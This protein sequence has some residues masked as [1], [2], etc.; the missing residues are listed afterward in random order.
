MIQKLIILG[1]L[2]NNPSS[3]YDIKKF[4][5]KELGVFSG[6]EMHSIYYPLKQ[7]EKEGVITKKELNRKKH[8][9]KSIYYITPKGEKE[10]INLCNQALLS[11]KRPFIDIDIPLY[12]CLI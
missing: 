1:F 8:L 2:K 7:M 5:E 12:F 3:G 4:I 11:K 9:K 10:F 6:L